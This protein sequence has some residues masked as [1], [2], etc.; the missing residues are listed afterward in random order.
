MERKKAEFAEKLRNK[1]AEIHKI[2][3]EKRA[4]VEASK[5]QNMLKVEEMAAKFRDAG[6]LPKMPYSCFK[7]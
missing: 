1:E 6:H 7:H 2:A 4:L 5:A 3:E